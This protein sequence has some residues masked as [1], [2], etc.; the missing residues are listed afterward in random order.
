M[1]VGKIGSNIP[2]LSDPDLDDA[3]RGWLA[4]PNL[5]KLQHFRSPPCT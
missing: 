3:W 2:D 5:A 4:L 1:T